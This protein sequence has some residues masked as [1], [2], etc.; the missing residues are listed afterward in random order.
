MFEKIFNYWNI[1]KKNKYNL[2]SKN[3][4]PYKSQNL[5]LGLFAYRHKTNI[6]GKPVNSLA[7]IESS[8]N[9]PGQTEAE[10]K[11]ASSETLNL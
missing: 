10:P 4:Y 5:L 2:L 7:H 8:K 1:L 3:A 11:R 9:R 6:N